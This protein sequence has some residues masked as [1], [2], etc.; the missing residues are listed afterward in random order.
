[1]PVKS[2]PYQEKRTDGE[3]AIIT[4]IR[5]NFLW[6]KRDFSLKFEK[7]HDGG[8]TDGEKILQLPGKSLRSYQ[9]ERT[10]YKG[11]ESSWHQTSHLQ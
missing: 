5:G 9:I 1:M 10:S 6:L 2:I 11:K 8:K 3:E 7:A 4:Q